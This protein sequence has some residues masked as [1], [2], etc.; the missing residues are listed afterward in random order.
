MKNYKKNEKRMRFFN[1][2]FVFFIILLIYF[3]I[4]NQIAISEPVEGSIIYVD[5]SNP[6]NFSTIQDGIDAASAGDI[7]FVYK[8]TY[9]ENIVIDKTI[10][11]I[12]ENKEN[13]IIDGRET[14]NV[15]KI[16]ANNV[17]IKGFTIQ[18][19]GLIFP[20]SGINISSNYNIIHQNNIVNN[21]YGMIL[22]I[23]SYNSIRENLIQ[24]EDSCGIYMS[25][26]S[27]NNIVNNTIRYN[28]YN[29][30]GVYDYSDSNL[31]QNNNLT[32]N[33]YSGVNIRISSYNIVIGNNFS[34][35]NI[36]VHIPNSEN[37]LKDNTFF[38]NNI[39]IDREFF[40][41]GAEFFTIISALIIGIIFI[42]FF[43]KI[44]KK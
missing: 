29:G 14:G 6:G 13:T 32:Q 16:N 2:L 3:L 19:S 42:V 31:I 39:D 24:N 33:N 43:W 20:N 30:I 44:K 9:Y 17:T 22:Y 26:S 10:T 12:G 27:N 23:S 38:G 1:K 8:G 15:V 4:N 11:L 41:K 36:G 18:H 21:L 28:V 5:K 37:I 40:I 7:V 34:E 25:K 35:N